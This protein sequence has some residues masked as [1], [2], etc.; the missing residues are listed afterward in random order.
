MKLHILL[1]LLLSSC[2]GSPSI[3]RTKGGG[4]HATAGF[5]LMAKRENVVAEITTKEGDVIKYMTSQ[6]EGEEVPKVGLAAWG[7]AKAGAQ[8]L[9]QANHTTTNET[10]RILGAQGVQVKQIESDTAIATGKQ[11]TENLKVLKSP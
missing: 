4:Y 1:F 10:K 7:V 5:V 3:T 11:A 9:S 6:E 2:V 8:A